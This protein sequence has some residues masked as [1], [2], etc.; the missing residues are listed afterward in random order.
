[1]TSLNGRIQTGVQPGELPLLRGTSGH[2]GWPAELA[3]GGDRARL[4]GRCE[5]A[6][7]TRGRGKGLQ[8]VQ[9]RVRG[10]NARPPATRQV[11]MLRTGAGPRL[12]TRG[13]DT[14]CQ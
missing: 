14:T 12:P 1:M 4:R 3:P 7:Q 6:R 8:R 9:G 5:P 13:W 11:R 10:Q 2:P